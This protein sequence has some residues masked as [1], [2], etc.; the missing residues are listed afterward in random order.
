MEAAISSESID[1]Y[2]PKHQTLP[3]EINADQM[4]E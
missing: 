1:A 2:L 4:V 3:E